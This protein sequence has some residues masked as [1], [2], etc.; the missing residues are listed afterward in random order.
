MRLML[1]AGAA[2]TALIAVAAV[3]DSMPGTIDQA[4]L[5]WKRPPSLEVMRNRYPVRARIAKVWKG[6]ATVACTANAAGELK[7]SVLDEKPS[8]LDFGKAGVI[9]MQHAKVR[10]V[11]G[12]SPAG[13]TFQYGLKFGAWRTPDRYQPKDL[14][15]TLMPS[16]RGWAIKDMKMG[17]VWAADFTCI[18]HAN[19]D[20]NCRL[21]GARPNNSSFRA[22]ALRAMNGAKVSTRDGDAP[23]EGYTFDYTL[24]VMRLNWCGTGSYRNTGPSQPLGSLNDLKQQGGSIMD[25]TTESNNPNDTLPS[26]N[27]ATC[28]PAIALTQ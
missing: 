17:D 4:G 1:A 25:L 18:T 14:E 16:F 11:D 13:R 28:T 22:A 2:F 20:L 8:G 26:D 23:K 9:V 21:L 27:G 3:A 10:T 12:S 7:C 6:Q 19:G 24:K 15:W 5:R